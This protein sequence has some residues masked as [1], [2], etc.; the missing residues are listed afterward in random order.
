MAT[1][2]ATCRDLA[3]KV[4]T[5]FRRRRKPC[6]SETV[7][8]TLFETLFFASLRTEE[9][10]PISCTL[11]YLNPNHPDP[12]PPERRVANRWSWVPF[13][14]KLPMA[15]G[16]LVKLAKAADPDTTSL[17]VY[18]DEKG[19]WFIWGM[20]DQETHYQSFVNRQR[21]DGPERPGELS[22]TITGIGNLSVYTD[23]RLIATLRQ[24][25]LIHRYY[26]VLHTGPIFVALSLQT[27][28]FIQKVRQAVGDDAYTK[29]NHWDSS[30]S[31]NWFNALSRLFLEIQRYGHGGAVLLTPEAR[32]SHLSVKYPIRY[33]R[34]PSSL[35]A[36]A[37]L[38]ISRCNVEDEITADY[39]DR[40]AEELP[41]RAYLDETV[42]RAEESDT[43]DEIA[44]CVRFISSLSCV[45]GL[46]LMDT[47]LNVNGFGV[48]ITLNTEVN[49]LFLAKDEYGTAKS[50]QQI[51]FNDFGTRHRSMIRY[52]YSIMGSIGFVISQDGDVRAITKIG[53]DVVVWDNIKLKHG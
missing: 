31:S 17:G 24:N 51:D 33:E 36:N 32:L 22:V 18:P 40:P 48:E 39:I 47:S 16:S 7:L 15:I 4:I 29:R 35:V 41:V 49:N 26:D 38:S 53:N 10:Q 21:S 37:V 14:D 28:Q 25:R 27:Q 5:T 46:V 34:L 50:L 6:P 30:L 8:I 20:I 9:L 3:K 45:D 23:Y 2:P 19:N 42:Y 12:H 43:D 11:T 44:G 1:K 13:G 52:C